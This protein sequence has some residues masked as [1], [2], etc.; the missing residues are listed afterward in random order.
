MK[1][2]KAKTIWIKRNAGSMRRV[3]SVL[4]K[5]GVELSWP[6]SRHG[7]NLLA[8]DYLMVSA[9][10][11]SVLIWSSKSNLEGV[12]STLSVPCPLFQVMMDAFGTQTGL[13]GTEIR[14]SNLTMVNNKRCS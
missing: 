11:T 6:W 5:A 7:V 3:K 4:E 14:R 8:L 1:M 10:M 12:S 9:L 13:Y 2:R